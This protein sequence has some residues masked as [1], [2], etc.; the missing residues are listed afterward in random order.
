ME[1]ILIMKSRFFFFKNVT[2]Q[3]TLPNVSGI[4]MKIFWLPDLWRFLDEFKSVPRNELQQVSKLFFKNDLHFQ[5]SSD[6]I[7]KSFLNGDEFVTFKTN[8]F[9]Y[10][11]NFAEMTQQNQDSR[12]LT[13]R[14]VRR[15]PVFQNTIK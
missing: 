5:F 13:K 4:W 3:T 6:A 2:F 14:S 11:L 1:G 12:Y 9:D 10:I 7:E 8:E 15:R